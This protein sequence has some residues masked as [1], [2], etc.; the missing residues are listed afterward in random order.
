MRRGTT[1]VEMGIIIIILCIIVMAGIKVVYAFSSTPDQTFTVTGK[2]RVSSNDSSNYLVFTDVTT[3]TVADTWVHGR[4]SSSDVYGKLV[5]GKTY[6]ATLQG[7]RIPFLS[8]YPNIID[9]V[10]VT[11]SPKTL[12]K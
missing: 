7:F 6:T 5:V 11:P 10:E 1:L 2:E 8:M 4:W 9:P 12:E 3:Y